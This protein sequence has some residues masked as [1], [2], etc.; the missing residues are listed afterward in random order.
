[1]FYFTDEKYKD[2][3]IVVG[4][5]V[6]KGNE[7][8]RVERIF[9]ILSN[10]PNTQKKHLANMLLCEWQADLKMKNPDP[11]TKC[12]YYQPSSQNT[13]IRTFFSAMKRHHDWVLG[14][15]DFKGF[16]G[17]LSA[18]L[19]VKYDERAAKYVSTSRC[20]YSVFSF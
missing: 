3:L 10:E 17:S 19:K 5:P 14:Y 1:M 15:D 7:P 9:V 13:M 6:K 8:L 12:P 11:D 18:L 4:N 2:L 20:L 16:E